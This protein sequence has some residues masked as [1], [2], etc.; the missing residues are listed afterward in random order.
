MKEAVIFNYEGKQFK[1]PCK[2]NMKMIDICNEFM[3]KI[4]REENVDS[5]QFHFLYNGDTIKDYANSTFNDFANTPDK[6]GKQMTITVVK[7]TPTEG[8]MRNI[9]SSDTRNKE[10]SF[11]KKYKKSIIITSVVVGILIILFLVI[12][13]S[14]IL[15]KKNKALIKKSK[16]AQTK[17]KSKKLHLLMKVQKRRQMNMMKKVL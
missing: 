13:S 2:R 15:K 12:L 6:R 10:V 17:A 8:S 3:K 11:F 16:K 1:V 5:Y 4:K 7:D 9:I 14:V